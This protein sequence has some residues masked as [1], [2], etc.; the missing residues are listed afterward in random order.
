M[1]KIS[2]SHSMSKDQ[3]KKMINEYVADNGLSVS[4]NEYS[5]SASAYGT[6]VAGKITDNNVDVEIKGWLEGAVYDRI[7]KVIDTI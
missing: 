2:K 3:V 5:F 6:K 1:K 4:W 7:K